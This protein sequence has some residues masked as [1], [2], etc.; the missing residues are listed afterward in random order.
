MQMRPYL[1][2]ILL[3]AGNMSF[4]RNG[5]KKIKLTDIWRDNTFRVKSVPGFKAMNDGL[6]Y[7]RTDQD[8]K[9]QLINKYDLRNGDKTETVFD[10]A[11]YALPDSLGTID[12]YSFSRD[13]KKMLL[14]FRSQNIYRRSVLH[15]V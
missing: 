5:T 7:T 13:E 14:L 2:V 15:Y 3:L 11:G 6:H 4:A 10:A 12:D 9:M 1:I 8:G